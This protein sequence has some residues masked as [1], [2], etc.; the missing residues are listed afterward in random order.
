VT[1]NNAASGTEEQPIR[2]TYLH[3][4]EPRDRTPVVVAGVSFGGQDYPMTVQRASG[5]DREGW[6]VA[7]GDL[8]DEGWYATFDEALRVAHE[9]I[10]RDAG[11]LVRAL[12]DGG[13]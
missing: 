1:G 4:D 9:R 8:A 11:E 6:S 3:P 5:G 2:I 12:R 13:Y 7:F 10:G